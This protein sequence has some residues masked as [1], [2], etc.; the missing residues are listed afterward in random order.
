MGWV[1]ELV[2]LSGR[3]NNVNIF[4]KKKKERGRMV[5]I[6]VKKGE[7]RKSEVKRTAQI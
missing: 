5:I 3:M 6:E 7:K 4:S 2:K 1:Y